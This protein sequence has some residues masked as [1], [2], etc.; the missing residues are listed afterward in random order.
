MVLLMNRHEQRK[1]IFQILFQLDHELVAL[2]DVSFHD[3]YQEYP[4]IA[5]IVD[6]HSEHK[7]KIDEEIKSHLTTYT[8]E[9]IPKA[10]RNILRTAISEILHDDS[11]KKVVINEAIILAKLYGE[12]DGYRFVNGVLKNFIFE[13]DENTNGAQ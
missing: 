10:E 9:R 4:Y 13:T 6:Y 11:P 1:K 2:E 3:L 7:S 8:L 5:S 12:K